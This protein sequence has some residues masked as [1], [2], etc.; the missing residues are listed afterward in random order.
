[1][2]DPGRELD[3][4]N[5]TGTQLRQAYLRARAMHAEHGCSY[6][7]ATRMLPRC[8]RPPVYALYGFARYADEIVDGREDLRSPAR[9]AA[10]LDQLNVALSRAVAEL[11]DP[12]PA[13]NPILTAVAHTVHRY[14]MDR[15]LFDA[16]LAS[17]R[18]DTEVTEYAS[19]E[20][21][22]RYMYGSAAV[23]GLQL[24]PVLGTVGPL[25]EAAPAATSLGIAFQ[26]TNF[27]RDVGEDL[28]RGRVY[29]PADEL[30][31]FGVDRA[32]LTWCRLNGKADPHVR[33]ALADL[34]EQNRAVYREARPGIELLLPESRHCVR[35]AYALY[36]AILDEI[37]AADY[38][39]LD[40]RVEVSRRRRMVLAAPAL[41]RAYS[42]RRAGPGP[43]TTPETG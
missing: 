24:L 3:A 15:S 25:A 27:L 17:M 12:D 9:K 40:R 6:F 2:A 21:L 43:M 42:T 22:D 39:V 28:D 19:R 5:I 31:S 10:A 14:V 23:I 30:S 8:R 41:L 37:E 38:D 34:V 26:L 29:L 16:F 32:L 18:M 13:Q 20:A 11:A 1:M 33:K 7:T 35:T 4:A 36:S